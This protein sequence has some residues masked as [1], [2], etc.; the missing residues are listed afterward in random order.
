MLRSRRLRIQTFF[1]R[2]KKKKKKKL[3]SFKKTILNLFQTKINSIQ[4]QMIQMIQIRSIQATNRHSPHRTN[5]PATRTM[6]NKCHCTPVS[7]L[8]EAESTFIIPMASMASFFA[9][10]G[11]C[12][13]NNSACSNACIARQHTLPT[14]PSC[15]SRHQCHRRH[16][17][18]RHRHHRRLNG[19]VWCKRCRQQHHHSSSSNLTNHRY[20]S[21]VRQVRRR[22]RKK[23]HNCLRSSCSRSA[24]AQL[25]HA[26]SR[27]KR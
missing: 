17:R 8:L 25:R 20:S 7:R 27:A 6:P 4:S 18:H 26:R 12:C 15:F 14:R 22:A 9:P 19:V 11:R 3:F 21:R 5:V 1:S 2:P 13:R 16:R 24:M 23:W 10:C